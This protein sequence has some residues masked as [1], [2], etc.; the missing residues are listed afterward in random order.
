MLINLKFKLITSGS[1][2]VNIT[3]WI[4]LWIL[5]G[6]CGG[7]GGGGCWNPFNGLWKSIFSRYL[8][9]SYKIPNL[10]SLTT[11]NLNRISTQNFKLRRYFLLSFLSFS[12]VIWNITLPLGSTLWK[13]SKYWVF[14]GPYFPIFS[15][16]RKYGPEK[17]PYFD[18]FHVV[19]FF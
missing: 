19:F 3:I 8:C 13:V 4:L 7:K 5:I 12:Y 16:T 1:I 9:T 10:R 18:T 15:P 2:S 6:R 14:S 17:A 11:N